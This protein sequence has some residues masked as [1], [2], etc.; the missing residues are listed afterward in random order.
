MSVKRA[1]KLFVR[2]QLRFCSASIQ[3]RRTCIIQNKLDL[4]Y[5]VYLLILVVRRPL[6]NTAAQHDC[7]HK[8]TVLCTSPVKTS[9][10]FS[11]A[12][13]SIMQLISVRLTFKSTQCAICLCDVGY[14]GFNGFWAFGSN[15]ALM[16]SGWLSGP[17]RPRR[18]VDLEN[19]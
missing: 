19:L 9:A 16:M 5:A 17:P 4:Q 12:V 1:F 10:S 18:T 11:K 13:S 3:R 2:W 15:T 8:T 14:L 6:W 7:S